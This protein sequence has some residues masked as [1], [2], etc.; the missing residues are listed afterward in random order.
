MSLPHAPRILKEFKE[1]LGDRMILAYGT[2]LFLIREGKLHDVPT[3]DEDTFVLAE[4]LTEEL[5]QELVDKGFSIYDRYPMANG[6]LGEISFKKEDVKI[7]IYVA[8]KRGDYRF[9]AMWNGN[10]LFH[11]IKAE[12]LENP[13][14]L[15]W[16]GESWLI[17]NPVE[18]YLEDTYGDWKTPVSNFDW[19]YDHKSYDPEWRL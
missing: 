15:E 17:P 3:D 10:S 1:V 18:A 5:I 9:W 8:H 12:Y 13:A 2:V 19:Q 16:E 6:E 4:N 11:K 14:V 7:D